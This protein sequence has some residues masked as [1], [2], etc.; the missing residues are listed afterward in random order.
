MPDPGV[1]T[2]V[3]ATK[4]MNPPLSAPNTDVPHHAQEGLLNP[5]TDIQGC[6]ASQAESL[7]PHHPTTNRAINPCSDGPAYPPLPTPTPTSI[8]GRSSVTRETTHSLPREPAFATATLLL[9]FPRLET[10]PTPYMK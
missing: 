8:P 2:S 10:L 3:N 4:S 5:Y 6:A 9:L 7:K 1:Q